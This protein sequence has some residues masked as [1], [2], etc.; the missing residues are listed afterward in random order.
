MKRRFPHFSQLEYSDCGPTCLKIIL[1][2]YGK[3]CR[4]SYLRELCSVT[5]TG[6]T[7]G[8]IVIAA[9]AL[10][11]NPVAFQTTVNGLQHNAALPCI[12]HW[13]QDHFVVLYHISEKGMFYLSDPG[14]GRIKLP[15]NEFES[16]W[17]GGHEK[18]VALFLAPNENFALSTLPATSRWTEWKKSIIFLLSHLK[19][20]R[21]KLLLLALFLG[22]S[23]ALA[24]IFPSTMQRLVDKGVMAHR[25]AVVW[26]VLLFQGC[27]LLGQIVFEW[28][29]GLVGVHFS[30]QVSMQVVSQFL[31]KLIRLPVRFF[32]NRMSADIL[33]R[34]EDQ[35][36]IELFLTQRIVQTL[37]SIILIVVLS[38]RLL[39][40][41]AAIFPLFVLLSA[42]SVGWI[43]LFQNH[44]KNIDYYNF[45]LAAENRNAQ[46]E[47]ITGMREVKIN[48]AQH[49]KINLWK[50]I[51]LEVY[52][53][54]I[55]SLRLNLYQVL[56]VN[57]ITQ[58]KNISINAFCALWVIRGDLTMGEMLSIG[59]ITGMLSSPLE[60]LVEFFQTAQDAKIS[61]DR[62][63]EINSKLDENDA[64]KKTPPLPV[65]GI[66][67]QSVSFKYDGSHHPY[68]LR[69]LSLFIPAGRVTAI[70]GSSGSGKTTLLKLLLSF[71]HPQKGGIYI[72]N[73]NM[74]DIN[75][76]I[77]RGRCGI[78]MQD[79]YIFSG[80]IAE[81][82]ALSDDNPDIDQ[83]WFAARTACLAEFIK[84]LPMQFNT[85]IG[86][87]GADLSGGQKQ[88]I[89]IARAVYHNP[90]ILFFDEATSSLDARNEKDI[91]TNLNAFLKGKTVIVVAHRLSTVKNADQ[92]IVL[93]GGRILEQG[94]HT[95]L[96]SSRKKYF[97]LIRN[98]LEL[99]H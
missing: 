23:T 63:D 49:S 75:S 95:E 44:R 77:W 78:V 93:E 24:Y 31:F 36:R 34:I 85:K 53:L 43:F 38:I 56:G 14:F 90:D 1:K 67:L 47:L 50:K 20:H 57:T 40:Y 37:F 68:V 97:E 30:T 72:D 62:I 4:L 64:S 39:H 27:I 35:Q 94:T 96:V 25:P 19:T 74:R 32:D 52:K 6:I 46:I 71:Y 12:L 70:V 99:G 29:R 58:L 82:I 48:N 2:Y 51:Q 73:V 87:A 76:D 10:H 92:I 80:T 18:G 81:N 26:G 42:F 13:R 28:L 7:M 8:D 41:N 69:D 54:K 86:N 3:E 5:R 61:F 55:R 15:A 98:Q 17:K 88:R 84:Q 9:R 45:R 33:Q 79:G 91:M 22:A 66:H 65:Q 60:S 21:W 59:Y 89:L 83:L 11:F 16:L